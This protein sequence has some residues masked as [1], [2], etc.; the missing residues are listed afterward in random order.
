ML[1]PI[2]TNTNFTNLTS[3]FHRKENKDR[4][5]N[6]NDPLNN[7]WVKSASYTNEIGASIHEIAPRLGQ[8]LWVPTIMYMGADIYDKYKNDKNK[9]NPSGK[10]GL[11]QAIYQGISSFVLPAGAILLGQKVT[12]PVGQ[13]FNKNLLSVNAK[14]KTLLHMKHAINQC[15]GDMYEDKE[16]FKN[17][18][19]NSLEN[20]INA[21]HNEKKTDNLFK[22]ILKFNSG[23]YAL[24]NE[25]R[26]KILDFAKENIDELFEIQKALKKGVKPKEISAGCYKKYLREVPTLEKMYGKDHANHSIGFVLKHYE[27]RQLFKNKLV[28]TLG[29]LIALAVLLKPIDFFVSKILMPKFVDPGIDRFNAAILDRSALK[30]HIKNYEKKPQKI[31]F[32]ES[33]NEKKSNPSKVA[34]PKM[35]EGQEELQAEM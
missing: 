29:G 35:T 17:F 16:Q 25:K 21:I 9:F 8:L 28:R 24:A 12:S 19:I 34:Y 22:K 3:I 27:N 15:V 31:S 30:S 10:R 4:Q 5:S 7:W 2:R 14:E 33:A 1:Y 13:L 6:Y 18:M 23:D 26:T 32:T 20:K 11:E